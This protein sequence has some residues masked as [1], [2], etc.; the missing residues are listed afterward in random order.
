[1]TTQFKPFFIHF[2]RPVTKHDS[3]MRRS[4]PRGFTAYITPT[5]KERTVLVQVAFC[6]SK[7]EFHKKEGRSQALKADQVEFN[8]RQLPSI[9]ARCANACGLYAEERLSDAEFLY[10]LKYVL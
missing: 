8:P 1:M 5:D 4:Q 2:S 9:L 3:N 6:A 7:D 10:V